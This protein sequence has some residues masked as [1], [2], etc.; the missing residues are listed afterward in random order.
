MISWMGIHIEMSVATL[1]KWQSKSKYTIGSGGIFC[2]CM[3]IGAVISSLYSNTRVDN[4]FRW[5]VWMCVNVYAIASMKTT[6]R[7]GHSHIRSIEMSN[8]WRMDVNTHFD[9]TL[10]MGFFVF[11]FGMLT[12]YRLVPF[13]A[14]RWHCQRIFMFKSA[15][16]LLKLF[17]W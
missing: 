7:H 10:W 5:N 2:V 1:C 17:A 11:F 14:T 12:L 9:G 16:S 13:L 3:R 15:V 4:E 6:Y 8:P